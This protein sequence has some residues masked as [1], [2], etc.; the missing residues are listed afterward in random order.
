MAPIDPDELEEIKRLISGDS[1]G[2]PLSS[3]Q[4]DPSQPD[5]GAS[6]APQAPDIVKQMSGP[7]AAPKPTGSGK[8]ASGPPAVRKEPGALQKETSPGAPAPTS[9]PSTPEIKT[10]SDRQTPSVKQPGAP[11]TPKKTVSMQMIGSETATGAGKRGLVRTYQTSPDGEMTEQ[12]E[13]EP[14]EDEGPAD[15]RINFDFDGVYRDVPEVKPIRIRRE[16][17]TGCVGGILYAVFVICVSIILASVAWL[18]AS[19]V[20]GFGMVDEQ[21]NVSVPKDFDIDY[22]VD[23][24]YD[25]GLV[26]YKSLF[27]IYADYSKAEDKITAGSYVLN[28]NFDYRAIVH[29]MT[30][31]GGVLVETTVTIPEGFTMAEIFARLEDHGVCPASDL[32]TTATRHN[33]NYSFLSRTTLGQKYRLEGYLFPD[34]YNFYL[35]SSPVQVINTLLNEFNRRLTETYAERAEDMGYTI[36][37][38]ITVASM[39]E[40]EAGSNE[41]RPRIAAVIYNRLRSPDFPRLE[42]DATLYYAAAGTGR[43]PSTDIDSPYN[44]YLHEGLPPGPIS[45]PGLESIRAALYPETT[46]EYYY[47]LNLDGVHEFFRT[48]EQHQAFVNSDEYGGRQ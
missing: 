4:P 31:R 27:R 39:I 29:G 22:I 41:E 5:A 2:A 7:P 48:Y 23:M 36:R 42:I 14:D 16:R 13:P 21:V 3:E 43:L 32:W 38:I 46:N 34:T 26:K 47:A 12:P 17:R 25:A 37:E 11:V 18:A 24:L 35:D 45:N 30:E 1:T 6:A 19:D 33:F 28:R 40:R 44:T 20:M 9:K 15:F 10:P 8:Q